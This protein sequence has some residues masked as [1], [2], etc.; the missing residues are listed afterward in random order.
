MQQLQRYQ[1]WIISIVFLGALLWGSLRFASYKK[2]QWEAYI[3]SNTQELL[4]AKKSSLEK[5]LYS[6]TRLFSN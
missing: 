4:I 2:G 3:R 1:H 6:Q 5:A